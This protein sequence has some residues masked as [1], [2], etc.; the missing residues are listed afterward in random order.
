MQKYKVPLFS[1]A[2]SSTLDSRQ[3]P[4]SDNKRKKIDFEKK[5][6]NE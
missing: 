6:H 1:T 4:F 2:Y 5:K 3:Q